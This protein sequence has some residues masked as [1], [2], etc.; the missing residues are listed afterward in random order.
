[1]YSDC[2]GSKSR[3]LLPL[4]NVVVGSAAAAAAFGG[5][6]GGA[7]HPTQPRV[8]LWLFRTE[9]VIHQLIYIYIYIYIYISRTV[10]ARDQGSTPLRGETRV[11][12]EF[13]FAERGGG[14]Q[15]R[16]APV[17]DFTLLFWKLLVATGGDYIMCVTGWMCGGGGGGD[18]VLRVF[19]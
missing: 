7:L 15:R 10:V 1:M 6:E 12:Q 13:C 4:V 11:R 14:H 2:R 18:V 9:N 16:A 8:V 5:V 19:G 3:C 17:F